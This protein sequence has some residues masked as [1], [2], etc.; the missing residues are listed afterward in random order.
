ME[1]FG[2]I[3]VNPESFNIWALRISM[4]LTTSIFL[5]GCILSI[6][7]FLYAKGADADYLNSVKSKDISPKDNFTESVSKILWST[8]Q[9]DEKGGQVAQ[10]AFLHDATR[11]VAENIFEGKYLDKISMCANLLPPSVCGGPSPA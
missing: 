8:A 5:L 6:R 4:S 3:T 11:Q 10:N 1:L 2:I 7:A 9:V